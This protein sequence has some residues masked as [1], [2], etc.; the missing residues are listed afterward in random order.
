MLQQELLALLPIELRYERV[1]LA[2]GDNAY[3]CWAQGIAAYR[4]PTFPPLWFDQLERNPDE[5]WPTPLEPAERETMRAWVESNQQAIDLCD[6]G[7]SRAKFHWPIFTEHWSERADVL[8]P[9]LQLRQLAQLRW[10]RAQLAADDGASQLAAD[11]LRKTLQFLGLIVRGEGGWAECVIVMVTI[12]Q[13]VDALRRLVMQFDLPAATRR[14]LIDALR[15]LPAFDQCMQVGMRVDLC[16]E[17]LVDLNRLPDDGDSPQLVDALLEYYFYQ[18]KTLDVTLELCDEPLLDRELAAQRL[19]LRRRQLQRLLAGHPRPFDKPATAR[20]MGEQTAEFLRELTSPAAP[21]ST[22]FSQQARELY[23]WFAPDA[24]QRLAY[25]WPEMLG[26][27]FPLE[28][29]GDD[30]LAQQ[31]RDW[32]SSGLT[33]LTRWR[34]ARSMRPL[35]NKRVKRYAQRL[36]AIHNPVGKVI[37]QRTVSPHAARQSAIDCTASV[38]RAIEG[39]NGGWRT[40]TAYLRL[41]PA[42]R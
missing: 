9:G 8:S 21:S 35:T 19:E 17:R 11:E 29:F 13:T 42:G 14:D 40:R 37:A 41:A 3:E 22:W 5:D 7:A 28:M 18:L 20:L 15:G 25:A 16:I 38:A 23:A 36:R 39:L 32:V 10:A 30:P 33:G 6:E 31:Q 26:P 2:D 1:P 12:R 4:E 34:I 27:H 24:A